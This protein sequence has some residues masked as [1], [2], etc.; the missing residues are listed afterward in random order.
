MLNGYFWKK[1]NLLY[2]ILLKFHSFLA[3]IVLIALFWASFNALKNFLGDKEY[4]PKDFRRSLFTLIV[5]HTQLLVGLILYF[6]SPRFAAWFD[7][8]TSIMTNS[9]LRLYLIEHPIV[10]IIVIALITIGY[11]K[12]KRK[13]TSRAKLKKIAVF[14]PIA[15]ILLLT[16]I[17][18]RIWLS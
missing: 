4:Q 17:P 12:H 18:W 13:L 1:T 5:S 9:L 11:S 6:V 7:A 2:Y 8:D 15:F 14:F 3:F 10:N 16:R